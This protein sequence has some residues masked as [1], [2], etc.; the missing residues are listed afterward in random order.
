MNTDDQALDEFEDETNRNEGKVQVK[1]TYVNT[2][3]TVDFRVHRAAT[4]N[5]VFNEAYGL[6]TEPRRDTDKFFCKGGLDLKPYLQDTIKELHR[7]KICPKRHY[8]IA[9]ETGGA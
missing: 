4:L 5:D 8:E 3:E 7:R 1:V 2:S 9:G 6:L